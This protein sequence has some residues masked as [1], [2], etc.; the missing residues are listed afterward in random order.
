M[1]VYPGKAADTSKSCNQLS[2]FS[3]VTQFD[4]TVFH[5]N[6]LEA[7]SDFFF[8]LGF[9]LLSFKLTTTGSFLNF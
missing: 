5:Y 1:Q 6:H 4:I 7:V 2:S 8:L 9:P 3:L